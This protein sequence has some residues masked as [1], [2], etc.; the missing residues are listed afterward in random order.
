MSAAVICIAGLALFG[1][2][3]RFYARHLAERV[4]Q[5]RADEP[6]PSR[7][8]T[9]GVDYV[10]TDKH[11]LFGHH[12][13]SIA[14]A[15]PI[16]GPAIAVVWG[17]VPAVLWVV[18]GTI[19]LGAVHDFSTLVMSMRHRGQ[20]VGT[21]VADV[22]GPRTRTLFLLVIFF[23]VMLVIAVFAQAIGRLF[24][25]KPGTVIPINFEIIIAVIIGWVCYRRGAGLFWPSVAALIAL[26]AMVWVGVKVP[27][28]LEV[29]F[30]E[31]TH[32]AWIIALLG[33]SFVASV[34]PVWVLLQPRDF[35]NAHQLLV[36]LTAL[37]IGIIVTNP[38]ITAP[39][40]AAGPGDAPMVVPFLFV[41]IACGAISGFH[42]LVSSGTTSKQIGCA[43]DARM[44]GYGGMLGEGTLALIATLAVSAGLADW[45]SHY[46][47]FA[48]ASTMGVANFVTGAAT[49]LTGLGLPRNPAEV[50]VA[51][52]VISFAATS[53][54]TGVRIQR[55]ILH[56]LGTLYGIRAL[57]NRYLA[58][59][60]AVAVPLGLIL[61]GQADDLWVLFG[62]SNQ[63]LAGLSLTVVTVWLFRSRRPWMIAAVPMG[64][65]FL[66]AGGAMAIEIAR[67]TGEGNYLLA[68][69]GAV[70]LAL[71]VWV[72]LEGTAAMRRAAAARG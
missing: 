3:Y 60:V 18:L 64:I 66:A 23:L 42:G 10:P 43:T 32:L 59:A 20:S 36:G 6:V 7:E 14:G 11:V 65:V 1:L 13:A 37:I 34:L 16:I 67:F 58:S 2:G 47:S 21:I 46:H 26:Y 62:S 29:V 39:A 68:A 28:S 12:Y 27:V 52:L 9:D 17:W 44:I 50:V 72:V 57:G 61:I 54:D 41:T 56:E 70:I 8:Q 45:A 5:L 53:L 48:Q 31:H 22:I 35:I 40:F 30:G 51:V 71:E 4:F 69:L 15:A 25:A 24:M 38:A 55:Y 19:F 49:F 33:Y 63:L